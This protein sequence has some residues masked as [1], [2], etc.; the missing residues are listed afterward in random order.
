MLKQSNYVWIYCKQKRTQLLYM[1]RT[2]SGTQHLL[3]TKYEFQGIKISAMHLKQVIN[4][5]S[6]YQVRIKTVSK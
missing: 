2:L 4:L 1:Y 3:F 5:F 6:F